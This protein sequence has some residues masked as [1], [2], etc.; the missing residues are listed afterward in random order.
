MPISK[1]K[2]AEIPNIISNFM[3]G[4]ISFLGNDSYSNLKGIVK[5]FEIINLTDIKKELAQ[6]FIKTIFE[7]DGNLAEY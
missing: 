4:Q 6:D 2:K 1:Q 5:D 7:S 3:N